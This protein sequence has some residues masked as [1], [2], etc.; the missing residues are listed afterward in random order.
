MAIAAWISASFMHVEA[1][2]TTLPV[3]TDAGPTVRDVSTNTRLT[4]SMGENVIESCLLF[5]QVVRGRF[6]EKQPIHM[7][8]H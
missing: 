7:M 5:Q 3:Q 8:S 2:T 6:V 4:A 1:Q